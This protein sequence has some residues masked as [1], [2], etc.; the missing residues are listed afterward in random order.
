M[1]TCAKCAHENDIDDAVLCLECLAP[2]AA[3]VVPVRRGDPP[4]SADISKMKI[5]T[6]QWRGAAGTVD[7][8]SIVSVDLHRGFRKAEDCAERVRAATGIWWSDGED[9]GD[10]YEWMFGVLRDALGGEDNPGIQVMVL[11]DM[12]ALNIAG[13]NGT[14]MDMPFSLRPRS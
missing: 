6:W 12:E 11:D 2:K 7:P 10:K 3:V 5:G 8:L 4:Q 9:A 13:A 1:W 14:S